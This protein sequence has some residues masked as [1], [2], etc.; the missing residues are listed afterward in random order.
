MSFASARFTG[1]ITA[2]PDDS[3]AP[4]GADSECV[5]EQIRGGGTMAEGYRLQAA[6][7]QTV[8]ALAEVPV[9]SWPAWL[10]YILE[11]LQP[12]ANSDE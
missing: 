8:G 1:T 3:H 7:E 12:R 6:M 4:A 9:S 10:A 11:S 2:N 5:V